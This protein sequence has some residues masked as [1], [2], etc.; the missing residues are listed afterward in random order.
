MLFQQS[1]SKSLSLHL[2]ALRTLLSRGFLLGSLVEDRIP[3]P[4]LLASVFLQERQRKILTPGTPRDSHCLVLFPL[5]SYGGITTLHDFKARNWK[6]WCSG[7]S[8]VK[9][10][11]RNQ[12]SIYK[13]WSTHEKLSINMVETPETKPN[14]LGEHKE[15]IPI[16]EGGQKTSQK[17]LVFDTGT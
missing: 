12:C 14:P 3:V 11:H 6:I 17:D 7:S 13:G 4:Q 9:K 1:S 10:R 16:K 15:D 2:T 8:I 5:G